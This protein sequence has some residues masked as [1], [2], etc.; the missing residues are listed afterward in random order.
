MK[1]R[2]QG[3]LY[4][5]GEVYWIQYFFRGQ[6]FRESSE[7]RV[8]R[9]AGDLLKKRLGQMG[10]GEFTGVVVERTLFEDLAA[11]ILHDYGI[12]GRKSLGRLGQSI[13]HLR[14]VFGRARAID[15]THD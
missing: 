6:I 7:S 2:G 11:M 14:E 5:R 4:Q 13:G 10:K 15:I 9:V 12:N 8:R 1:A 3:R